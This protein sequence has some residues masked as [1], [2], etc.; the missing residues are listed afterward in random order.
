MNNSLKA[1]TKE[2]ITERATFRLHTASRLIQQ[3]SIAQLKVLDLTQAQW[4]ALSGVCIQ[5]SATLQQLTAFAQISQPLMSQAIKS[6]EDR[7]L[8]SRKTP[9][10]DKRS[11]VILA[12][13]SGELIYQQ[14]YAAMMA[15]D[16]KIISILGDEDSQKLKSL[17]DAIVIGF[18]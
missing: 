17:L 12:T 13:E 14:A 15:V 6:L 18:E 7:E 4:R 9:I 16:E 1:F 10:T 5:P 11:S 8:V 2:D 3:M